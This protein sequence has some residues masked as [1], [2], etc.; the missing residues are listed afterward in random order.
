MQKRAELVL[1]KIAEE[2]FEDEV[3]KLAKQR[4]LPEMG[5]S[6]GE[7]YRYFG[8]K[9]SQTIKDIPSSAATLAAG[10]SIPLAAA[11]I[12]AAVINRKYD[13]VA[14]NMGAAK[15]IITGHHLRKANALEMGVPLALAAGAIPGIVAADYT[16]KATGLKARQKAVATQHAVRA[17]GITN[18]YFPG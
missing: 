2:A 4:Y 6:V 18:K 9:A 1:E 12:T 11:G 3:E 8:E 5:E 10:I 13:K 15:K 14:K 17:Y 7:G 16:S